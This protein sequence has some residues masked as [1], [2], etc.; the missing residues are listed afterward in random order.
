MDKKTPNHPV[1]GINRWNSLSK[2]INL[3]VFAMKFAQN[4]S[5]PPPI[6]LILP[7]DPFVCPENQKLGPLHSYFRMGL[8][9]EKSYSI[10]RGLDP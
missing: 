1:K 7:K 2:T 8:E 6:A 10:G 3:G 4:H 5:N 9:P